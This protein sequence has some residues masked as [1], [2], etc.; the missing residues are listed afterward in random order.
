MRKIGKRVFIIFFLT[1]LTSCDYLTGF[2][3]HGV[4]GFLTYP[5]VRLVEA[6]EDGVDDFYERDLT[7][8]QRRQLEEALRLVNYC[9]FVSG[10]ELP[11]SFGSLATAINQRNC[12]ACVPWGKIYECR[13]FPDNRSNAELITLFGNHASDIMSSY[14]HLPGNCCSNSCENRCQLMCPESAEIL[15]QSRN[16]SIPFREN[17]IPIGN[18]S[19]TYGNPTGFNGACHGHATVRHNISALA[20]WDPS[21]S[22]TRDDGTVITNADELDSY[23][24]EI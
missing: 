22:P 14:T 12:L 19:A 17:T 21:A 11:A 4:L 15:A 6:F 8:A 7:D 10:V 24:S 16:S 13:A 20:Q 9:K 18:S 2:I 1:Q 5:L 3:G 23:Y